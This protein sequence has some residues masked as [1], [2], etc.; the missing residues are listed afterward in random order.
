MKGERSNLAYNIFFTEK[1]L[2]F[3]FYV[4]VLLSANIERFSVHV[5]QYAEFFSCFIIFAL[6]F[7]YHH[8]KLLSFD[9][10]LKALSNKTNS[11]LKFTGKDG[12]SASYKLAVPLRL[13]LL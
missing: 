6:L 9:H 5:S 11:F 1:K 12:L 7:F 8:K 2:Y 13:K 3:F 10:F 4:L